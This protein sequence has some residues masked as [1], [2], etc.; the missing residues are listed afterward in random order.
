MGLSAFL[1][2]ETDDLADVTHTTEISNLDV[3]CCGSVPSTP[4]ELIGSSRM[5]EFLQRVKGKYDRVVL[6][7]PPVSAVSD[8]L[9]ISAMSDGVIYVTKF[10]KIRREHGRKSVQR[11]QNA[12]IHIL[13]VVINDIDFEGKDSYYYSYYYYQNRYYSSHYKT[14]PGDGPGPS[15]GKEKKKEDKAVPV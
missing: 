6:D 5:A 11:I 13:G 2:R 4:S 8:P 3:V 7:C 1:T 14:T 12:G 9:I 10:N 15:T